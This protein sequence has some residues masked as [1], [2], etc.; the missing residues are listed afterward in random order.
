[1]PSVF[2][3]EFE[4]QLRS[5]KKAYKFFSTLPPSL[6]NICIHWVM[7][8]KQEKTRISRMKRLIASSEAGKRI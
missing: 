8:A 6:K 3:P 2:S 5:N 1:M 4:K 7:S